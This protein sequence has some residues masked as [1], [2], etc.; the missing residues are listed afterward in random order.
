MK[1][2]TNVSHKKKVKKGRKPT[3]TEQKFKGTIKSSIGPYKA[4][5]W[6]N[7]AVQEINL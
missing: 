4:K 5:I 2:P 7:Q 1:K 3:Y 6:P